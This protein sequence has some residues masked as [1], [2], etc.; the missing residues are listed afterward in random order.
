[1]FDRIIDDLV[2]FIA[3]SCTLIIIVVL[4]FS[5]KPV[6]KAKVNGT[7]YVYEEECIGGTIYYRSHQNQNL[8]PKIV[9]GNFATGKK[10]DE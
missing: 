4:V 10:E 9:N 1:M 2:G 5:D 6:E 7:Y 3:I 8:A